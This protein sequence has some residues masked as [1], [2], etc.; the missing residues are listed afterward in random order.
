MSVRENLDG[1]D[2]DIDLEVLFNALLSN[3]NQILSA[4]E[5]SKQVQL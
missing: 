5:K 1:T 2:S 3:K 4:L